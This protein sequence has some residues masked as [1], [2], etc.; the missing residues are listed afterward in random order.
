MPNWCYNVLHVSGE[1]EEVKRFLFSNLGLPAQYAP[2]EW[3]RGREQPVFTEPRFCF[4]ALVPIPQEVRDLGYDAGHKI[5]QIRESEGE[6]AAA[7]LIDGYHWNLKNWGTKWDI[8]RDNITPETID[9]EEGMA[10]IDIHFESAWSPPIPWLITVAKMF[11]SLTLKLHYEEPGC[12]FAGEVT[13]KGASVIDDPYDDER[14]ME[15]FREYFEP[16][17]TE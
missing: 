11:P 15:L 14:C 13:C 10:A 6:E 16:D 17:E 8:Y 9:W 4:N 12:F 1:A 2:A 7:K 3:E 5:A